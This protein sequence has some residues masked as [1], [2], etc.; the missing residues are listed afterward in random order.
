MAF[1]FLWAT[2]H[3]G[4]AHCAFSDSSFSPKSLSCV[5]RVVLGCGV[6][7]APQPEGMCNIAPDIK[8]GEWELELRMIG[9]ARVPPNLQ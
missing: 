3:C 7:M 2:S 5:E 1:V 8:I 4:S 9:E 6:P